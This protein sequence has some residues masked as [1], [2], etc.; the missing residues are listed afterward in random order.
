MATA[1]YDDFAPRRESRVSLLTH[2]RAASEAVNSWLLPRIYKPHPDGELDSRRAD[3][4]GQ[5]R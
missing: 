1:M 2:D 4:L 5:E 3:A